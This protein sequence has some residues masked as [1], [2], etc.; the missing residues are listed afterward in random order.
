MFEGRNWEHGSLEAL[1]DSQLCGAHTLIGRGK[2]K[3]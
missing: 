2:S 1:Q 3:L